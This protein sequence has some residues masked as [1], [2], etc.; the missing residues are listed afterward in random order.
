MIRPSDYM[1]RHAVKDSIENVTA[2]RS[3]LYLSDV[4]LSPVVGVLMLRV[5]HVLLSV[6]SA[7]GLLLGVGPA[8]AQFPPACDS[9]RECVGTAVT[10]T[11]NSGRNAHFMELARNP[12]RARQTAMT[13]EMWIRAER[14]TGKR[15]FV[16]GLWGPNTDFNDVFVVYIDENEDLVFEVNGDQGEL[17]S[18][19][20]TIVRVSAQSLFSGWHHIA[21]VFDGSSSSASIYIDGVLA[22]GPVTNSTYPT[23]YLKPLDRAD[24]PLLIG[25]C[26]GVADN[27]DLYRTLKGQVDEIRVWDRALTATE[28]LCGKDRSFNGNESG[29]RAYLRCNE[30]VN[31]IIQCCDAT[32]NAHTGLL[33]SG[34][35]NQASNRTPPRTLVVSPTQIR[36]EIKCDSTRSWTFT[37]MDSSVCGSSATLVMR[38]PEASLFT[39]TPTNV[40]FQPGTPVTVTVVYRGTNVGPFIDTLEIRP[41]NR[42]GLPNTRLRFEL[43]R[44]T[45]ISVSR[46]R[47]LF[48]SLWVGCLDKTFI[49]STV[50][51]CNTSDKLGRPRTITITS[52][53]AREPQGYRVV[54]TNFPL[55]IPPG[56][57]VTVTIRSL[58]R[59]TTA[60]YLDT[61]QVISDDLCQRTPIRIA[62]QGRSQEVIS[63]RSPDGSRRIDTMR[64]EPTCPGLLSAPREY[65]WQNLTQTTIQIDTVIVPKDFTHYRLRFPFVLTP[66]TGYPGIAVRFLPRQ[67]GVVFD[68]VVIRTRIDGCVIERKIYVTGRGLDNKVEWSVNGLVDFGNVI[69]G[70]QRTINVRARNTSKFDQLNIA[71]Y[72][73][74]GESFALLAGAGRSINPG[75]SVIIPITF[76]PTDSLEYLDRLCLFETRCYTAD[77]IDLRGR[78]V[79]QTFRAS[80]L[81]METQNVVACSEQR[82]SVYIVNMLSTA[83]TID[84]LTFVDPSG[85][86]MTIVDPPLPWVNKSIT[87]PGGDSALFVTNYR[88]NDVTADRADRAYIRYRSEDRAEWQVQLIGTSATP[89]IFVTQNTAFGT[90]EVGDTRRATLIVENTSS[91]AIRVDSIAIGTGYA[92]IGTSQ[93]LPVVL[94]PRDSIRVDVEFRPDASRTF[95][96]DIT[97][98]SSSPCTIQGRGKLSGRG[99]ILKLE[100]ALSLVNFGYARPCECLERKVELLNAS[101]RFDMT[102]DRMWIDSAGVPGGRP[103]FFTWRSKYSPAGAVPYTIPPGERDTV[104]ISFC[105]RTPADAGQMDCAAMLRIDARGSQWSA[106]L[107]TF[108]V[109][110][111]ALTFRPSPTSVQFPYGVVDVVSP[112]VQRVVVRIPD[113]TLNPSQDQV[114]IDSVTFEP[115]ER[116]FFLDAPTTW[117]QTINPGDSLVLSIR[118]RPRAPRDYRARLKMWMSKPCVGWDTTVLVRGGGFAQTRG[119]QFT[120]SQGR[121]LPDTFTMVSCDTLYVPLY[122]SIRIDASVVDASMRIDFD[123]TQLRLLDVTSPL[124][125]NICTSATG[126]VQFT[127]TRIITPS[128]YGGLNVVLKNF[129]GIDSLAPFAVLSFVT[130]ANNRA[131]SPLTVDSVNFDTEDVILYKLI[132][133]GD[134]ATVIAQKSDIVIQNQPRFDS[135]R[136]LEC[137]DRTLT[138]INTGDVANTLDGLLD[139]PSSVAVVNAVPA[140]GSLIPAGDSSVITLRFCPRAEFAIDSA[141]TGVSSTPC[142]VRDTSRLSGY[143]YAPELDVSLAPTRTF[144]LPDSISTTIGDTI[145]IPI[146]IDKDLSATYSGVTYFLNGLNFTVNFTYAPRSLKFIDMS[147]LAEP[148]VTSVTPSLGD[149]QLDIRGADTIRSG[150]LA[151]LR[152]VVTVPELTQSDVSV[153]SSGYASDSL[154]FLDIVPAGG[155]APVITGERCN[156]TVVRYAA[157]GKAMMHVVPQP[158][159]DEA[160]ITFRMQETVPVVIDIVDARGVVVQQLLDGTTTLQGGEYAVRARTSDLPSGIYIVRLQAGVFVHNTPIVVAR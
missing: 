92:I 159:R 33:R 105:P 49:D 150:P 76:R 38:G 54:G 21:A 13:F 83:A 31:N 147:Y 157:V 140:L 44:I 100:N 86:R 30:P 25:S 142:E 15:Q 90:V 60:D 146:M 61:I 125:S 151:R 17:K 127:P 1:N 89:K 114:V 63:I 78:G 155:R 7:L 58:V 134:R 95:D 122:S 12:V 46:G 135:V 115:N 143:G 79:L 84:S 160:L 20:N 9:R 75:D 24:L 129:C 104:I 57:C 124:L 42:C 48:D 14:Q 74:K 87:I 6:L 97:V 34:A 43:N 80:P 123:T 110:K 153:R 118:Q 130:V 101:L 99:V 82:D 56:E 109:G 131:N 51:V 144:F 94:A 103:Q 37:M 66:R 112:T 121:V 106:K 133:T 98:Y 113:Y 19:D 11:V 41:T 22:A 138:V 67:P 16:G 52:M 77:C 139:L 116:V 62:L 120:F 55:R 5:R 53:N 29:L 69:V 149:I 68:S 36:E 128:I 136:I 28:I 85:G 154:Q 3:M 2:D 93:P 88:P 111:R 73:E 70:Q 45:E 108:L 72:V 35:S 27:Q 81:V 126:G 40:T 107:E 26:N 119:L 96:A 65:V 132:A 152:F 23:T 47:V 32:G 91:L 141:V 156:I 59:D 4:L 18:A 50:V 117:P 8:S 10:F 145:E 148:S 158:V 102:V 137:A 39:V 64:F 71:L